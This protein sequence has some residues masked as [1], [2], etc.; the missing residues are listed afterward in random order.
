MRISVKQLRRIIKEAVDE[1]RLLEMDSVAPI[2][3]SE[4]NS[5]LRSHAG[6][7]EADMQSLSIE[8]LEDLIAY[9]QAPGAGKKLAAEMQKNLNLSEA[10]WGDAFKKAKGDMYHSDAGAEIGLGWLAGGAGLYAASEQFQNAYKG[11]MGSS[12]GA[13]SLGAALILLGGPAVAFTLS[14][15]IRTLNAKKDL[16]TAESA[17]TTRNESYRRRH[18]V[19]RRYF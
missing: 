7:I 5:I 4:V 19:G 10:S 8:Q 13:P 14:L 18:A 9:L 11:I 3:K 1:S 6:E 2:G 12:M 17:N 15:A 16:E